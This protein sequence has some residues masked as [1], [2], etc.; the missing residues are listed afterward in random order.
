MD[1][2]SQ[3]QNLQP[4]PT[5]AITAEGSTYSPRIEELVMCDAELQSSPQPGTLYRWE[6]L[7]STFELEDLSMLEIREPCYKVKDEVKDQALLLV[8]QCRR[9]LLLSNPKLA[10]QSCEEL[11]TLGFTEASR[12]LGHDLSSHDNLVMAGRLH[13]IHRMRKVPNSVE[14]YLQ[15][16]QRRLNPQV[17]TFISQHITELQELINDHRWINFRYTYSAARSLTD[18][19]LLKP[20]IKSE[21]AE[22]TTFMY[23]RVA[24]QFFHNYGIQ[25]VSHCYF[26]LANARFLPAT[27]TLLNAGAKRPQM[28][29]CFLMAIDDE[30]PSM[31]S[32]LF[33]GAMLSASKGGLG[34]DFS[35]IRHSEID[36]VSMSSGVVPLLK[37]FNEM[38]SHVDQ[39]GKRKGASS[40]FLR[41]YH[42]DIL[43]F[44]NL[45]DPV[46][47][48]NA[49]AHGLNPVIWT[50]WIFWQRVRENGNWT[51]FCPNKVPQLGRTYGKDFERLYVEAEADPSIS[52][53]FRKT[54]KARELLSQMHR[55]ERSSGKPFI[56][57]G[58][59]C[60]FKSPHR[61][62]GYI[63][64]S[65][66]CVSRDT[67]LLTSEGY[68]RIGELEDQEVKVWNG[69]N[70]SES[71]VERTG[72][73]RPRP[74]LSVYFSD[75]SELRCTHN[76]QFLLWNSEMK[77]P[78]NGEECKYLIQGAKRAM[79][80]ELKPGDR[81]V[82]QHALPIV[83][84]N[85]ENIKFPHPYTHAVFCFFGAEVGGSCENGAESETIRTLELC[86]EQAQLSQWIELKGGNELPP[87]LPPHLSVPLNVGF[88][89]HLEWMA[90]ALDSAGK[91]IAE[92]GVVALQHGD[93]IFL[94]EV[95]LLG[96][97]LGMRGVLE[98]GIAWT[99][100]F[101]VRQLLPLIA[102]GLPIK[103][104]KMD[105]TE[106]PVQPLFVKAVV[107]HGECST[108]FCLKESTLNTA[109]FAGILTGQ[110]LEII[111][112]TDGHTTNVCN[113]CS[114]NL[115][116]YSQIY[117]TPAANFEELI[118]RVNFRQ[119][120]GQ[121]WDC[122]VN[123]NRV[124]DNNYYPALHGDEVGNGVLKKTNHSHRAIGLG[125]QG[126][127]ELFYKLDLPYCS[128]EAR[129]LDEVIY[130]SMY[131]NALA[132]SCQLAILEGKCAIFEGSTYSEGK[133]QFHLWSEEHI[134]RWGRGPSCSG[135]RRFQ[136]TLPLSPLVWKQEIIQL[137][138][139]EGNVVET[140]P[141]SWEKLAS[142]VQKYGLRN[143]LLTCQMPTASTSRIMGNCESF[144]VHLRNIYCSK[145]INGDF[146]FL[147][148]W[149][150]RDLEELGLWNDEVIQHIISEDAVLTGLGKKLKEDPTF[151]GQFQRE[152]HKMERLAHLEL[153]Y[154]TMWEIPQKEVLIRAANRGKYLDQSQS[155]SLFMVDATEQKMTAAHLMADELGLKTIMYYLR[156]Q[157]SRGGGKVTSTTTTPTAPQ[158][159]SKVEISTPEFRIL[160]PLPKNEEVKCEGEQCHWCS[161]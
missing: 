153:K 142:A 145:V 2:S 46:G 125:I 84:A 112:Y 126:M 102:L 70:W 57:G 109:T 136:D 28:S 35:P 148:G 99:L 94:D 96:H 68:F 121:V 146:P 137:R 12:I 9:E 21:L 67:L 147:N 156:T 92:E 38:L 118:S 76:H 111:E 44:I 155:M 77:E 7:L 87:D 1:S 14:E 5:V 42:I 131:Y 37:V 75:G 29:S 36:E 100:K 17:K 143:S 40:V 47:D 51:L 55:V 123:L 128:N 104:L 10:L 151:C 65:N 39:G 127:A 50:P 130:A 66:L 132:S 27:P 93:G 141:P 105:F 89:T 129:K 19:Y 78:Q 120:C 144:E 159:S 140:I 34:I 139:C 91:Y 95:R 85:H 134:L 58:D 149:M 60:N 6:Q 30:L 24:V 158:R 107:N 13:L 20:H 64:S 103:L 106:V 45:T 86:G 59:S 119:Y 69:V 49:R 73:G 80:V 54:I 157:S 43:D 26:Q 114:I 154:R 32:K 83:Y 74:L 110:C 72:G 71:K 113:L 108:T 82:S 48:H 150:A 97:L 52:A 31:Y 18:L 23:L 3:A 11:R 124:I 133:L 122:V 41:P 116:T 115:P 117:H 161:G 8:N 90:G 160:P 138:D 98:E 4:F 33:D 15:V 22:N 62:L 25:Q 152:A 81:I 16:L 135:V 53:G 79:A 56:M 61:H 88:D 101:H 63:R